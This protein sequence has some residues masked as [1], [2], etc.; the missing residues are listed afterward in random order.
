MPAPVAPP[1][2]I[3]PGRLAPPGANNIVNAPGNPKGFSQSTVKPGDL[4]E[5][6][7][8]FDDLAP[9]VRPS[10]PIKRIVAGTAGAGFVGANI[11]PFVK[12]LQPV[13]LPTN[14]VKKNPPRAVPPAP[15]H[16]RFPIGRY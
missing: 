7:P 11:L 16:I 14:P 2:P 9:L 10:S 3:T 12:P 6:S 1:A 4:A 15:S 13:T 8:Y 5:L